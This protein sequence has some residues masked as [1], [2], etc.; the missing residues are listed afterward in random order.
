MKP[1]TREQ[2]EKYRQ[3]H[4]AG[5]MREQQESGLSKKEYCEKMSIPPNVF[6]YWQ[7][8][9]RDV[10]FQSLEEKEGLGNAIVP[11]GWS[12]CEVIKTSDTKERKPKAIFVEIGKYRVRVTK[13]TDAE[14]LREVCQALGSLC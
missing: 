10:V 14:L 8:K 2:T 13:G 7:R 9:L 11:S 3:R 4:W 1:N 6:Y 12:A 5:V